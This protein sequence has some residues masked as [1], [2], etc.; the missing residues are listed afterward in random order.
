[1]ERER[2]SA[3]S[4]EAPNRSPGQD[5]VVECDAA[6]A[7]IALFVIGDEGTS[8]FCA[9]GVRVIGGVGVTCGTGV[10][11]EAGALVAGDMFESG[12]GSLV[13]ATRNVPVGAAMGTFVE[14]GTSVLAN[15]GSGAGI[16]GAGAIV[17]AG[18]GAFVGGTGVIVMVGEGVLVG[19]GVFVTVGATVG[20]GVLVAVGD[21][22]GVAVGDGVLVAVG[23][24]VLVTVGNGVLVA[25]G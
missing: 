13:G 4:P 18:N 23:D 5:P 9:T 10:M 8:G 11:A 16:G 17:A 14:A 6:V 7:V 1:M 21:G 2:R 20:D 12:V 15:V 25:V 24:G 19:D 3:K 22:V